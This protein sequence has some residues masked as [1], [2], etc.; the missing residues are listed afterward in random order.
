MPTPLPSNVAYGEVVGRFLAVTSDG[1]DDDLL[2]DGEPISGIVVFTPSVSIALVGA[3]APTTLVLRPIRASLDS[4]GYVYSNS[5]R[6]VTLLATDSP[7]VNPLDFTWRISFEDAR[8]GGEAIDI[9]GFYFR[10]PG[11]QTVDLTQQTPVARSE[12]LLIIRGEKGEP[13]SGG[14]GTGS[15]A[16]GRNAELRNNGTAIQWRLS[17]TSTWTDL[18][19]LSAITGP[20]GSG[21][22]D[23][24]GTGA[25]GK[26]V[27]LRTTATAIEWRL[28]GD[29]TWK[30]VAT[31]A[32]LRGADGAKGDT[33]PTGPQGPVGNV[34]LLAA[35][36]TVAP[37]D[38]G[39]GTIIAYRA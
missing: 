31:L 15:G 30:T 20:P 22:G 12:G 14:D 11:G 35:G 7:A 24:T 27:E 16:D 9:P 17:G 34:R 25:D 39:P 8:V 37:T 23:G 2:P 10:V 33:G 3:V 28:V 26:S 6:G 32:S 13:G 21:S 18:V 4:E 1:P 5:S 38:A 36:V 19:Q 29:T